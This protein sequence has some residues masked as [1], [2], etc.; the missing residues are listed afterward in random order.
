[1]P[2]TISSILILLKFRYEDSII[3]ELHPVDKRHERKKNSLSYL[4]ERYNDE[5]IRKCP[6][7]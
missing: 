5:L 3:T 6:N 4:K 1:M 2:A 7:G